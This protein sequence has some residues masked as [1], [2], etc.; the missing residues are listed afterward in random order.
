MPLFEVIVLGIVQ[1]LTEFLP[2]SSTAHLALVPKLF[3]WADPGLSYDIALHVGTLAAVLIYFFRDWVQLIGQG[4]GLKTGSDP[5]LQRNPALFWLLVVGTIP[6]G[7]A[8]LLFQKQAETNLRGPYVIGSALIAIGLFM[9]LAEY[10]GQKKRDL[11]HLSVLDSIS[12]GV[13]QAVAV[14]PGVSR[15]GI[16]IS[17][18]LLRDFERPP[19]ARFSFLMSTPI[20]LG[21]AAKDV[22]DLLRHE[23][24]IAPEMRSAFALGILISG[25][26]GCVTIAFFMNFLRS[27]S[28]SFFV[29]YRIILG[30]LVLALANH[31][32]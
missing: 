22:W 9:W 15:S 8:G 4:F 18:G 14:I 25:I 13:A 24:G 26:T 5:E 27:R 10:L 11:S 32:R 21:A 19:A 7:L 29:G 28:L 17:A 6:G 23:G 1:G 30:I 12:I 16:T 2:V 31:F 3:G 20:I